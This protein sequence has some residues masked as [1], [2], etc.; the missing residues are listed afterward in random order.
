MGTICGKTEASSP[1]APHGDNSSNSAPPNGTMSKRDADDNATA[2]A[3]RT[4][5]TAVALSARNALRQME[6][7]GEEFVQLRFHTNLSAHHMEWMEQRYEWFVSSTEVPKNLGESLSDAALSAMTS[8]AALTLS[9]TLLQK[10]KIALEQ[11]ATDLHEAGDD[12]SGN[13]VESREYVNSA[14]YEVTNAMRQLEVN[15]CGIKM[16]SLICKIVDPFS[17]LPPVQ[18]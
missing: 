9:Q 14:L 8:N 18:R 1:I 3:L 4:A 11:M 7:Y 2:T 10:M 5:S 16:S 6:R 15:N 13:F 17:R 12:F